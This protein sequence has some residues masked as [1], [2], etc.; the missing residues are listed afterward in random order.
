MQRKGANTV[1]SQAGLAGKSV[2]VQRGTTYDQLL[3]EK[4]GDSVEIKRY[5]TQDEAYL[6][7]KSG[8]LDLLLASNLALGSG[9]LATPDGADFEFVGDGYSLDEIGIAVR[10]QDT[11]LTEKLN[12]AIQTIRDNGTYEKIN[13]KYF[14]FDIY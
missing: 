12:A 8:R 6:D 11:D 5:G 13:A 14:D 2:G 10:K 7:I 3:S 1:I 4:F 9:F